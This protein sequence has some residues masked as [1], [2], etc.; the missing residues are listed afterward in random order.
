[1]VPLWELEGTVV[2]MAPLQW[3]SVV[4]PSLGKGFSQVPQ[5][6]GMGHN[7]WREQD[8]RVPL[9]WQSQVWFSLLKLTLSLHIQDGRGKEGWRGFL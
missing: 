9:S 5:G 2:S 3:W 4:S 8:P 1:M 6:L 7:E